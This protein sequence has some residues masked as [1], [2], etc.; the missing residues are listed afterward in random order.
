VW[1]GGDPEFLTNV[2]GPSTAVIDANREMWAFFQR[3]VLPQ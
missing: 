3:F 1:P 2:L